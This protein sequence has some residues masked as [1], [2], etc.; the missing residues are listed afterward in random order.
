M[1]NTNQK[2]QDVEVGLRVFK[3][4]VGEGIKCGDWN[5]KKKKKRK[6]IS[7]KLRKMEMFRLQGPNHGPAALV[8]SMPGECLA[9]C[10]ETGRCAEGPS[11]LWQFK[12]DVG[13]PSAIHA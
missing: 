3:M 2:L 9:P 4:E 13:L 7:L 8:K 12:C 5:D 11:R 10:T 6:K 1:P